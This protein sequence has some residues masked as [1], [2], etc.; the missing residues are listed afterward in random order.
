ML[1]SP[2]PFTIVE[3]DNLLI[4][5]FLIKVDLDKYEG[6]ADALGSSAVPISDAT[7]GKVGAV[8]PEAMAL[9]ELMMLACEGA[10][11]AYVGTP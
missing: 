10:S 5:V 7:G 8:F 4:I 2:Y 6:R 3:P 1:A 9:S 11:V